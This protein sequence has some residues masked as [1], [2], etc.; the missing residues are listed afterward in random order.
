[1]GPSIFTGVVLQHPLSISAQAKDVLA[2]KKGTPAPK[3]QKSRSGGGG[4][5]SDSAGTRPNT[6]GAEI[7]PSSR[8][9]GAASGLLSGSLVNT[10]L[11]AALVVLQLLILWH[12]RSSTADPRSEIGAEGLRPVLRELILELKEMRLQDTGAGTTV[13]LGRAA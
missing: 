7:G 5:V 10:A 2:G 4:G 12:L 1:M 11:L 8:T 6:D 9:L 3:T 13:V